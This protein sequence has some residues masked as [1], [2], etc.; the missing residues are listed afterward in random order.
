MLHIQRDSF[1]KNTIKM[2]REIRLEALESLNCSPGHLY[3]KILP[4]HYAIFLVLRQYVFQR[5]S[6][7]KQKVN[8]LGR[9]RKTM[10][11]LNKLCG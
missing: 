11:T 6:L 7:L 9:L 3:Q 10:P 2:E 5:N 8:A 1:E 4:N